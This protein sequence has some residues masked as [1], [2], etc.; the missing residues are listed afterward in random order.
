MTKMKLENVKLLQKVRLVR[1]PPMYIK[2]MNGSICYRGPGDFPY[3]EYGSVGVVTGFFCEMAS[4]CNMPE[5]YYPIIQVTNCNLGH[6][7]VPP[8]ALDILEKTWDKYYFNIIDDTL[9]YKPCDVKNVIGKYE[10]IKEYLI[11][12]FPM[13]MYEMEQFYSS[14]GY[15]DAS[16][17]DE[18]IE[19]I[20]LHGIGWKICIQRSKKD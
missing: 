12:N 1:V 15:K 4:D 9:P 3:E 5:D 19:I 2:S 6:I 14:I 7:E 18:N 11:Y 8:E 10:N 16:T 13:D 17:Y 20:R